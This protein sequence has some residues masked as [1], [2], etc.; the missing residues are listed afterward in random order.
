LK[1]TTNPYLN[2]YLLMETEED[3]ASAGL[4]EDVLYTTNVWSQSS[5][6]TPK[7]PATGPSIEQSK[8]PSMEPSSLHPVIAP[9]SI[10]ALEVELSPH[11]SKAPET[12]PEP[13]GI[14]L[15]HSSNET[16]TAVPHS[17]RAL[18]VLH[19]APVPLSTMD[20]NAIETNPFS[21]DE[22]STIWRRAV[23]V[24]AITD[25]N[26]DLALQMEQMRPDSVS[27]SLQLEDGKQ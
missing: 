12:E 26:G 7:A 16:P 18:T 17:H 22:P 5:V 23:P 11:P 19:S 14:T 1:R 4:H 10:T 25:P 20:M 27:H 15:G 9:S 8:T 2:Y 24:S 3:L 21:V 6:A 13:T